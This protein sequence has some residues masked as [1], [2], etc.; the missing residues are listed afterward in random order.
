[1]RTRC[2]ACPK[3][4]RAY[5]PRS[6]VGRSSLPCLR[7]SVSRRTHPPGPAWN[8]RSGTRRSNGVDPATV[9][10]Q[11]PA[12]EK[13]GVPAGVTIFVGTVICLFIV[14]V[15]FAAYGVMGG[16]KPA[17]ANPVSL[18][19]PAPKSTV[20]PKVNPPAPEVNP[21]ATEPAEP[22]APRIAARP[23]TRVAVAFVPS[24]ASFTSRS[25]LA[26]PT[27]RPDKP[28]PRRS[29]ARPK[30]SRLRLKS[31][32]ELHPDSASTVGST[33]EHIG[34]AIQDGRRLHA[35]AVR[36]SQPPA[37]QHHDGEQQLLR[38]RRSAGGVCTAPMQRGNR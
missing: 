2:P 11:T 25:A 1:M 9:V 4:D 7:A 38:R 3:V 13:A 37:R 33:D 17:S 10:S 19:T 30:V 32:P 21:T 20:Q 8:T 14:G 31:P 15:I 35:S 18:L 36:P 27:T 26:T 6:R 24:T 29:H 23:T 34:K 5:R 12:E 16:A 22:P 28:E